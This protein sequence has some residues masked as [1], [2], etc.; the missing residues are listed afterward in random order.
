MAMFGSLLRPRIC[1]PLGCLVLGMG[2]FA[3]LPKLGGPT[4]EPVWVYYTSI[5]AKAGDS[6]DC[7]I[8]KVPVRPRFTTA[9]ACSA[10]RDVDLS[11]KANPR[12]MGS[13]LRQ[14]EA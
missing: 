10:H 11:E 1:L 6:S 7:Q 4:T 9:E 3:A 2:L 5:C 8:V 14:F 13:C 12:L